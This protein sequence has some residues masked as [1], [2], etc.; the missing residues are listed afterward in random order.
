MS[1]TERCR[2]AVSGKNDPYLYLRL[3]RSSLQPFISL[4]CSPLPVLLFNDTLNNEEFHK[5][6]F[7]VQSTAIVSLSNSVV[8]TVLSTMNST[9]FS[10]VYLFIC[11]PEL[12][13]LILAF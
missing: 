8:D 1:N 4:S 5:M 10:F 6:H 7:A 13:C 9:G 11:L 12:N 3:P 2:D